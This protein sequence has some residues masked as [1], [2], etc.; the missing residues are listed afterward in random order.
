VGPR[1]GLDF[2]ITEKSHSLKKKMSKDKKVLPGIVNL[3]KGKKNHENPM[4][5]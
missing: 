5:V 2:C 1:A 3:K 4:Q